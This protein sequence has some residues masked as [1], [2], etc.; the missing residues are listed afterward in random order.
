MSEIINNTIRKI[1]NIQH[2]GFIEVLNVHSIS[3][4]T[5]SLS[6]LSRQPAKGRRP[7]TGLLRVAVEDVLQ[8][9]RSGLDHLRHQIIQR[10]GLAR[11][12]RD[13]RVQVITALGTGGV[14]YDQWR[15]ASTAPGSGE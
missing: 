5:N 1:I 2:N 13:P 12:R 3:I 6:A 14:P 7:L 10:G 9:G 11:V 8:S 15:V 4:Q